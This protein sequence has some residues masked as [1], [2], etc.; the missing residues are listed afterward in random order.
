MISTYE[1]SFLSSPSPR[2]IAWTLALN[3]LQHDNFFTTLI[4]LPLSWQVDKRAG[5]IDH[6]MHQVIP[7]A[8]H[9]LTEI[10]QHLSFH[11]PASWSYSLCRRLRRISRRRRTCVRC[12]LLHCSGSLIWRRK[13]LTILSELSNLCTCSSSIS[14]I[15]FALASPTKVPSSSPRTGGSV[16]LLS[17]KL[18]SVR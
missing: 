4:S 14:C 13:N 5:L 1:I 9:R 16:K 3:L 10:P 12:A 7:F 18:V 2:W 17:W 11:T 8:A 15:F 6:P